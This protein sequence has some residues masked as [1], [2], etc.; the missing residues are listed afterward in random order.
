MPY[1][2]VDPGK[3]K[4]IHFLGLSSSNRNPEPKKSIKVEYSP[5]PKP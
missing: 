3:K 1:F 4:S 2:G 5:N